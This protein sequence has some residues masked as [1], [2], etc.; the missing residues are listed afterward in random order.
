MSVTQPP[1]K[2]EALLRFLPLPHAGA[3]AADVLVTARA[4]RWDPTEVIKVLLIEE[5][6]GQA[7]SRVRPQSRRLPDRGRRS[8][9]GTG[10]P[11]SGSVLER[12]SK[13][14]S[15]TCNSMGRSAWATRRVNVRFQEILYGC[16]SGHDNAVVTFSTHETG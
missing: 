9:C 1:A 4:Q 3:I 8:M 12:S 5:S 14:F 16:V 2:V 13:V 6:A 7:R 10:R 15:Y 11:V